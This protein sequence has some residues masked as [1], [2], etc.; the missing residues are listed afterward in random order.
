MSI[1]PPAYGP[2][3]N[4]ARAPVLTILLM[5]LALAPAQRG[6]AAALTGE[7]QKQVRAATYEV[8]IRKPEKESV[9]YE[10][11]LPLE[12]IPFQERNDKYWSI[13]TAFAIGPNQFVTAAHVML[14]GVATQFGVLSIRDAQGNVYPIDRVLK[15]HSHQDFVV[16][17]V[18]GAPPGE[19]LA[20]NTEAAIDDAV[21]AV[22]N[23]LGD[24]VVIRDGLLT[25]MTPE[26]KD[27]KWKWLRF[28]AAASPGN[29]GGPLLDAQGRVIGVVE[30]KSPSENLNYALPIALVLDDPGKAAIFD[31]RESFGIPKL[32]TG[33]VVSEFSDSFP[34]PLPFADFAAKVRAELVKSYQQRQAKLAASLSSQLFPRGKSATLLAQLYTSP[35]PT[36]VAQEDDGTWDARGCEGAESRLP[37]DGRVWY[38]P[39]EPVGILFRLQYPGSAS[40][41]HRYRDSKE[42][43]DLLLKGINMPRQVGSQ[44][45][46]VTSLGP[47]LK[48]SLYR[49][50]FG[51]IWQLRTW[52]FGFA[53]AYVVVLALPTPDGY[54]GYLAYVPSALLDSEVLR[55]EFVADYLYLSYSGS[56]AQWQAFLQRK[57]LRPEAFEH[58]QLHYELQKAARIESPRLRLDTTGLIS[59]DD[60]SS[61][62]VQMAYI[63]DGAGLVWDVAGLVVHQDRDRNT[64]VAAYRQP[65]PGE[66]ASKERRDRWDHMS[67]REAEFNGRPGHDENFTD[68]WI[69]TV[70]AADPAA[71]SPQPRPLYEIVYS[72]DRS[73]LPREMEDMRDRLAGAVKITE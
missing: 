29:S 73:L 53:E 48:D 39:C 2:R 1:S 9:T 4:A 32:L 16:F 8:V 33:T 62:D 64:L 27:G 35:E 20:T 72:T 5:L 36:L 49:D 11:P 13:G 44:A 55:L 66:D 60:K 10:K 21:F 38:C 54:V 40:D 45:V 67:K 14:G 19:T 71:K 25:S 41:E 18:G 63:L 23:A 50:H 3:L 26:A 28:S 34:L 24:G 58:V 6:I 31:E 69:R 43:M 17:S 61:L 22:G 56:L 47:A 42:F 70:A 7:L 15:F 59:V 30:A 51:R 52:S 37:G 68:F 65:K 46:R 57:E 12:L